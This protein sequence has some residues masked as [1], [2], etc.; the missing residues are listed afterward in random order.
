MKTTVKGIFRLF[1][2]QLTLYDNNKSN[3]YPIKNLVQNLSDAQLNALQ[4]ENQKLRNALQFKKRNEVKLIGAEIISFDPSNWRRIITV[5][6]GKINNIEPQLYAIN[7]EGFLLGKVISSQQ[8]TSQIRLITDPDFNIPVFIGS[9]IFGLL[10]GSLRGVKIL[11]IERDEKI[12]VGDSVWAQ[13]PLYSF[14]LYIGEVK[15]ITSP[16]D[17]LFLDV[18]I[19]LLAKEP[20]LH[21]IFILKT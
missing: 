17:S 6:Q 21:T 15:K 8:N 7:E 20:I 19:N 14:P 10:Q 5:N 18:E 3:I 2:R 9:N 4:Q 13:L 11:Y 16:T 12:N 1:S